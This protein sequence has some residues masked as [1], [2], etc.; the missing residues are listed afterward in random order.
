[1]QELDYDAPPLI[2]LHGH[3][4]WSED[5]FADSDPVYVRIPDGGIKLAA[6]PACGSGD[7]GGASGI[8]HCYGCR[9]DLKRETTP[10]AAIAWNERAALLAELAD[11]PKP[12]AGEAA[13]QR[14][15]AEL[16]HEYQLCIRL[17]RGAGTVDVFDARGGALD[18]DCGGHESMTD[19]ISAATDA[20]IE[21]AKR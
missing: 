4:T 13:M 14:A 6:C 3:D 20:A 19:K 15:A 16:P 2:F 9:L 5:R 7:V 1:M 12:N 21:D 18:F 17:E 8:I 10:L 11:K